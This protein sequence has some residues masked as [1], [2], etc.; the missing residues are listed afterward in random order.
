M[1][2]Q[3]V[4]GIFST[5]LLLLKES[6]ILLGV[7]FLLRRFFFTDGWGLMEF[8]FWG[9]SAGDGWDKVGVQ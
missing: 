5:F 2:N 7:C 4:L 8:Y 9:D 6:Q 1:I 3:S